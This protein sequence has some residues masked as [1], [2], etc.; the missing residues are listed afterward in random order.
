MLILNLCCAKS[1]KTQGEIVIK[2][3][4]H[5]TTLNLNY[6]KTIKDM[7]LKIITSKFP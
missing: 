6:I 1:V 2:K 7:G 5:L 4:A 3:K